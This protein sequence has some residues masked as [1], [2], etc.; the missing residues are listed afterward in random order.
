[1]FTT[2]WW[3][4]AGHTEGIP[5]FPAFSGHL[6]LPRGWHCVATG[7]LS[8]LER[9]YFPM[10]TAVQHPQSMW[11][12]ISLM[13]QQGFPGCSILLVESIF[14]HGGAWSALV[15]DL[16]S[17][18][19]PDPIILPE[20]P[21]LLCQL[22]LSLAKQLSRCWLGLAPWLALVC[23]PLPT[24]TRVLELGN[25]SQAVSL[26]PVQIKWEHG[27]IN[28]PQHAIFSHLSAIKKLIIHFIRTQN[29]FIF[30]RVM[31]SRIQRSVYSFYCHYLNLKIHAIEKHQHSLYSLLSH[32]GVYLSERTLISHQEKSTGKC[33]SNIPSALC[34]GMWGRWG[35]IWTV[36]TYPT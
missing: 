19:Q 30:T 7:C 35:R 6:Q 5:G 16:P 32:T 4:P 20:L 17:H 12:E 25:G 14:H 1:M 2:N 18:Q 34:Y 22:Q 21:E 29:Q 23:G 8:T 15:C 28:C 9:W 33:H 26:S 11:M 24:L 3:K 27:H 31:A 10:N 36:R 13:I